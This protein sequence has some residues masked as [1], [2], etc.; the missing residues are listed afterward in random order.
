ML[1]GV[2]QAWWWF[3]FPRRVLQ[4]VSLEGK[5]LLE[6]LIQI[7]ELAV[8]LDC[9]SRPPEQQGKWDNISPCEI[10]ADVLS[11]RAHRGEGALPASQP[12]LQAFFGKP[13]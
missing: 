12:S 2:K 10:T 6:T 1:E 3:P 11:A 4:P 9:P 8:I 7:L 13:A 5:L